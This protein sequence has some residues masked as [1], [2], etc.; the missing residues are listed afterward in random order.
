M[1]EGNALYVGTSLGVYALDVES[2]QME[3]LT[4]E[5]V[6]ALYY[7]D[8]TLWVGQRNGL[9][10]NT[11][12]TKPYTL[13]SYDGL[14]HNYV[15]GITADHSGA[16]WVSTADGLTRITRRDDGWICQPYK[17]VDGLGKAFLGNHAI[18]CT[19]NGDIIAGGIGGLLRVKPQTENGRWQTMQAPRFTGLTLGGHR[20]EVGEEM[21][22]GRILLKENIM[23]MQTLRLRYSDTGI[24]LEVSAMDYPNLH[25]IRYAYRI[26]SD[27]ERDGKQHRHAMATTAR[28][29]PPPGQGHPVQLGKSGGHLDDCHHPAVV[30]IVVGILCLYN[31]RRCSNYPLLPPPPASPVATPG[32]CPR[33]LP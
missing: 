17:E 22:D 32:G 1:G 14:S 19:S 3:R 15:R 30:A 25:H 6:S 27:L 9:L 21:A 23:D 4:Q 7:S 29:L 33:A 31:P 8:Q 20:I 26:N 11:L 18:L 24:G 2:H 13:N 16:I 12:N 5:Y 10:V 28:H